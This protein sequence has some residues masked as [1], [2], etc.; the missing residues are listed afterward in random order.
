VSSLSKILFAILLPVLSLACKHQEKQPKGASGAVPAQQ[1]PG[2]AADDGKAQGAAPAPKP[3]IYP[4]TEWLESCLR[5]CSE[6]AK[7]QMGAKSQ[8]WRD[9]YCNLNCE[10]GLDLMT[11]PGPKPGEIS[12]P[13]ARWLAWSAD[14]QHQAALDCDKRIRTQLDSAPPGP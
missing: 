7:R 8:A 5:P 14:Q 12:T 11:A 2:V 1:A 4:R 9:R 13:S 3:T 6:R 10:C